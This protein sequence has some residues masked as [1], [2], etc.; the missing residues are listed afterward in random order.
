MRVF[1]F[2]LRH[3]ITVAAPHLP[4]GFIAKIL[5]H[6]FKSADQATGFI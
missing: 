3:A 5:P 2:S 6:P 1:V 4:Y